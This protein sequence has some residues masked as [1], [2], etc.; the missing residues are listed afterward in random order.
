MLQHIH[1]RRGFTLIELSI[2][3][4][5][6]SLL[7][8]GALT[9][10]GVM[11]EQQQFTGSNQRVVDAKKALADYFAVNGRLPCPAPLTTAVNAAGFGAEVNCAAGG[12]APAGTSRVNGGGAFSGGAYTAGVVRIGALPVRTL[13]LRDNAM[14]DDYGNRIVYA[15]SE[16]FADVSSVAAAN[17]AIT[18][19]DAGGNN[20]TTAGTTNGGVFVVVGTGPDGKGGNRYQ[21]GAATSVNCSGGLDAENCDGDIVFRDTRFNNGSGAANFFDDMIAWSPKY[22]MTSSSTST[23]AAGST[24]QVQYNNG[25][26]LAANANFFWDIANNRL[27]IGTATPSAPLNVIGG[28]SSSI[29][30]FQNSSTTYSDLTIY[31]STVGAIN[32]PTGSTWSFL[33]AGS[34]GVNGQPSGSMALHQ[35]G[36]GPRLVINNSG[37]VSIGSAVPIAG[38]RLFVDSSPNASDWL[39]RLRNDQGANNAHG[40]YSMADNYPLYGAVSSTGPGGTWAVRGDAQNGNTFGGL[41]VANSYGAYGTSVSGHGVYASSTNNYAI[42]AL[43]TNSHGIYSGTSNANAVGVHGYNAATGTY[44]HLGYQGYGI[45]A[46]GNANAGNTAGYFGNA[47]TGSYAYAGH[48]P[49]GLYGLAVASGFGAGGHSLH[50]GSHGYIGYDIQGV[51]AVGTYR[52]GYMQSGGV[53]AEIARVDG[54]SFVGNYQGYFNGAVIGSDRRLKEHIRPLDDGLDTIMKLKPVH[55]DWKKNTSM[56]ESAKFKPQ[57]GLIAQEVE[58]VVPEIVDSIDFTPPKKPAPVDGTVVPAEKEIP[59]RLEQELGVIK[60]LEYDKFVPLL[61]S[62]VQELKHEQDAL[63][64]ENAAL[65]ARLDS[66][67]KAL[68]DKGMDLETSRAQGADYKSIALLLAG[69][70]IGGVLVSLRRNRA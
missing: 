57:I 53:T 33:V 64:E 28:A 61:I 40:L 65:K 38:E 35:H 5:I 25:G 58:K 67:E 24:G 16:Q 19:Q 23:S 36:S 14:S 56:A 27:G 37:Q 41:G 34:A 13:G 29:G 48:G 50:T 69:L 54:Y 10:G 45:Y 21:S 15:M 12:A 60:T 11:V 20:I 59:L 8:A 49:H 47:S 30:I 6:M 17:G 68:A 70:L 2:G 63:K 1:R 51:Y 3:L 39:V 4:T 55:Y 46:V 66:I 18:L 31:N 44:A 7:A 43:S 52:G 9:V 22:L 62:S 26:F 42:N 32:T